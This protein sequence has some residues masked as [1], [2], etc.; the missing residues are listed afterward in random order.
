MENFLFFSFTLQNI[1]VQEKC[2][3][4]FKRRFQHLKRKCDERRLDKEIGNLIAQCALDAWA[5]WLDSI[6]ASRSFSKLS[7]SAIL[8]Q[9][10]TE[11]ISKLNV[12][13]NHS[14]F[15]ATDFESLRSWLQTPARLVAL[16]KHLAQ[17]K[18]YDDAERIFNYLINQDEFFYPAARYYKAF[19][20]V[21]QTNLNSDPAKTAIKSIGNNLWTGVEIVGEMLPGVS[22]IHEKSKENRNRTVK[23]FQNELWTAEG[24]IMEHSRIQ[25]G[26]GAMV[27]AASR[28]SSRQGS[29]CTVEGYEKQK[30][31]V[32]HLMEQYMGNIRYLLGGFVSPAGLVDSGIEEAEAEKVFQQLL[33]LGYVSYCRVEEDYSPDAL[34]EICNGYGVSEDAV[35]VFLKKVDSDGKVTETKMLKM[36]K[37][38]RLFQTRKLFWN[39]MKKN[40]ALEKVQDFVIMNKTDC[41]LDSEKQIHLDA[42]TSPNVLLFNPFFDKEYI[43]KGGRMAFSKEDVKKHF[44]PDE[45]KRK[46]KQFQFNKIAE[47]NREK[48]QKINSKSFGRMTQDNLAEVKIDEFEWFWIWAELV[49][50][51]IVNKDGSLG[52]ISATSF[53]YPSCPAYQIGVQY[54][55]QRIFAFERVRRRLLQVF[56]HI[57][58]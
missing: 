21:N 8:K 33:D 7:S 4:L 58:R 19:V 52:E 14:Q 43:E 45:Y 39:H 46:R 16:G 53:T 25:S 10:T 13:P 24:V 3:D 37:S 34:K 36:L 50:Q 15:T 1:A 49:K 30:N 41:P 27:T 32:V 38:C 9:L 28:G 22:A 2:F 23:T 57:K 11:L 29:V 40:G 54:A 44:G 51:K 6:E 17:K 18:R 48:L 20:F 47:I 55:I 31:N 26:Y 42:W 56:F 12:L 5:F 35:K